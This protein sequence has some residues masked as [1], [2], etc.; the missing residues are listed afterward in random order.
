MAYWI[1][2]HLLIALLLAV[3]FGVF[4]REKHVIGVKEALRL[5][6]FWVCLALI[7]NFCLF[8]SR[9]SGPALEFFTAFVVEKSLSV[10]NLFVFVLIFSYFQIPAKNQRQI[11]FLG[12]L[13]A[14]LF[15]L[16][17]ILGGLALLNSFQWLSYV[18]GAFLVCTAIRF[19][20]QKRKKEDLSKNFL[21]RYL[22]RVI[23]LSKTGEGLV[24][25]VGGKWKGTT[26][27]LAL[28]VIE[29]T[30][31]LFALDS[32][33]AVF[34]ITQDPFIAY[35]SN[36]FAILGLRALYFALA[37]MLQKRP[38]FQY[39]LAGILFFV[40][41]KMLLAPFFAIPLFVS[42]AVIAVLLT[43]SLRD[44]LRN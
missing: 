11:L 29:C 3:D 26:A 5:S 33:P 8:L 14:L 43:V 13:G 23:P 9:G 22:K 24:V 16:S 37:G 30:D 41:A 40:G 32:I 42:L 34:A 6:A 2:F 35:T 44:C 20:T 1:G 27:L 7:F 17:F 28:I 12:I 19:G 38:Y 39:G 10:D 31:I 21:I 18:F 36:V 15:R 25:R 4:Q